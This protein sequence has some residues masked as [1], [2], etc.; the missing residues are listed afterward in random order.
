MNASNR[1][2]MNTFI[3]YGRM[4]LTMLMSLL[5]T[6]WILLALGEQDFGI[7]NLLAGIVAMMSFLNNAMS[8]ATQRYLS[9]AIGK[10]DEKLLK[11]TF[12]YSF[13]QFSLLAVLLSIGVEFV[14]LYL[15]ENILNIPI[16][17]LEAAKF[18]LA[19]LSANIVISIMSS[20]FGATISAHEKMIF[21]AIINIVQSLIKLL[22]GFSLLYYSNDRLKLYSILLIL[23]TF[24]FFIAT[25]VYCWKK[26]PEVK[27]KFS[28]I[29]DLKFFR[30]ML[31]FG[32]LKFLSIG[33][34]IIR[35]QGIALVINNFGGLIANAAYGIA[36]QLNGQTAYFSN[37]ILNAFRPQI[38]KSEGMGNR[39][40]TVRLSLTACKFSFLLMSFVIIPLFIEAPTILSLWLREVPDYT[41]TFCRQI[42]IF[43]LCQQLFLG[44]AD[45]I[46]STGR[47]IVLQTLTSLLHLFSLLFTYLL[48]KLSSID[49]EYILY[50]IVLE[51]LIL[52]IFLIFLAK[53]IL[54]IDVRNA[55]K[56]I[57][58]P[59]IT[60]I[61]VSF[62]VV[63]A[64]TA[65]FEEGIIRIMLAVLTNVIAIAMFSWLFIFNQ[66]DKEKTKDALI[67]IQNRIHFIK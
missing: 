22:I 14:G 1:V 52:G 61:I 46:E 35:M 36:M 7:Y 57:F 65:L 13:L 37:V 60:C 66:Y 18:V 19:C 67:S 12:Y 11:Q 33:G 23:C 25:I 10:K 15:I 28:P 26:Y 32:L 47:V 59:C 48:L 34:N 55:L 54:G 56:N 30:E 44:I 45:G 16:N 51:E 5:S 21:F 31:S 42:L 41:I 29:K 40:R 49:I 9:F 38:V 2:I 62:T 43:T 64:I 8:N 58:L 39:L 24:S 3:L 63:T 50:V 6:R 27:F 20:P 53:S 4:A 17:R